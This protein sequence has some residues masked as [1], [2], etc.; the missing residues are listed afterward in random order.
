MIDAVIQ[1]VII[2]STLIMC[3]ILGA[4][5]FG[6]YRVVEHLENTVCADSLFRM[7]PST[8]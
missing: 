2:Q 3:Y 4:K 6:F 5:Q 8:V 7:E 1:N